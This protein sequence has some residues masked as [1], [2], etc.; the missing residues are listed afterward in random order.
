V[1]DTRATAPE[2]P[3]RVRAPD[4]APVLEA[5]RKTPSRDEVIRHAMR[6]MRLVARRLAV[7]VCK[8]E[9]FSGWACN[10]DFGDE[11]ALRAIV[12]AA[13]TP[14]VLATATATAM[15]LGPIPATP[16]HEPL[17]C[18]MERSSQDVAAVAVR[19]AGR[20]VLVLICDDLH[21]TMVSSRY[22]TELAKAVGEALTRLISR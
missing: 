6:G 1:E 14:S 7:F 22:L 9:S 16:A 15:Y 5:L 18:V 13:D 21:D 19:V 8:R 2:P 4:A 3:R 17:L 20:A 12:I 11:D 10:A